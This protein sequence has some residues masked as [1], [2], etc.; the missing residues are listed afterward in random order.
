MRFVDTPAA[1]EEAAQALTGAKRLYI[2]TEFESNRQGTRLCLLQ[3]SAG[4]DIFLIDTLRLGALEPLRSAFEAP[5]TEWVLHAGMQ[6]VKLLM[7]RLRMEAPHTLFDT[8]IAWGLLSAESSVSLAYLQFRLLGL[9]SGKAHQAD[10]W[11]RRP[12]PRSQLEYAASDI[13][14]LPELREKLARK[15]R[16]H[17]REGIILAAS[18]DALYP[19]PEPPSP[20]T[21]GSF[22]NAWQLSP[23]NQAALR[24]IIDWF[25]DLSPLDR[26]RAPEQKTLLSI[27]SR[28]PE[29]VD[30]LIRIKG[31][32]RGWAQREGQ[33]FVGALRQAANSARSEDFVPI[34]PPPY[35]TFEEIRL[36]AWLALARAE[37]CSRLEVS[38]EL[39][40]PGR[41]LKSMRHAVVE[42]QSGVAAVEALTGWRR[43]LVPPAF[44]QFC[45]A[46]PAPL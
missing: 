29:S 15:A 38:P 11:V 30:A 19:A 10:D 35:S 1:L 42:K 21:L 7:D 13:V 43:D 23:K 33:A 31:V 14:H 20:I 2:D 22:R 12:L 45:A 5:Q 41:V 6:D 3:V 37:V 4:E 39:A 18:R 28:L 25:N 36:D 16:E 34:D 26:S 32:P 9:R 24:Y 17:D 27:A 44:E 46:H 8:Q 40:L